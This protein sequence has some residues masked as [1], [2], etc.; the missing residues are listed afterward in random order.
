MNTSTKASG[1]CRCAASNFKSNVGLSMEHQASS[2]T[3]PLKKNVSLF[4]PEGGS[5]ALRETC[6]KNGLDWWWQNHVKQHGFKSCN[7]WSYES[8]LKLRPKSP[9]IPTRNS[10]WVSLNLSKIPLEPA[11]RIHRSRATLKTL[12][13]LETCEEIIGLPKHWAL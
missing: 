5:S 7:S 1:I 11:W 9:Q 6:E 3:I 12:P 8:S 13:K 2:T 4:T 10:T